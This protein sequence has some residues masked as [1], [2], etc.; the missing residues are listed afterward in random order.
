MTGVGPPPIG[1]G[2][3][4]P[5]GG[6]TGEQET[7]VGPPPIG[8]GQPLPEEG[9]IG[10]QETGVGPPPI[11][12]GQPLPEGGV[13]SE[14]ETGVGPPP[15]GV[16]HPPGKGGV[17]IKVGDAIGIGV[18]TNVGGGGGVEIGRPIGN[19]GKHRSITSLT[20]PGSQDWPDPGSASNLYPGLVPITSADWPGLRE[21]TT[22]YISP[23]PV[24]YSVAVFTLTISLAEGDIGIILRDGQIAGRDQKCGHEENQKN[25]VED[26]HFYSLGFENTSMVSLNIFVPVRGDVMIVY[27]NTTFCNLEL[28]NCA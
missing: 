26:F 11:G 5:E 8:V 19:P 21:P 12:V 16:G 3:P 24:R 23:G 14:Q 9:G 17:A 6:V 15:I 4:L 1:V 25:P 27:R 20:K 2:Q 18:A 28:S 22:S 10:E 13:T 7:G